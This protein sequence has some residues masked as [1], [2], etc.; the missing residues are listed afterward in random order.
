MKLLLL[1]EFFPR[2]EKGE[3]TGGVEARNFYLAKYFKG[4]IITFASKDNDSEKDAKIFCAKV[5]RL[6]FAYG[7]TQKTSLIK[8]F[9]FAFSC[10]FH[11]SKDFDI[12]EG[13]NF[14][15]HFAAIMIGKMHKKQIVLWYPDVWVGEWV[16]NVG[17]S[18]IFGEILERINLKLGKNAKYISISKSTK[19]KLIKHGI[20]ESNIAVIPCGVDEE[21]I[22]RIRN[23]RD[24]SLQIKFDFVVVNRLVGYKN[25]DLIIKTISIFVGAEHCSAPRLLIVGDGP[26]KENL[27]KLIAKNDIKKNVAIISKIEN[28]EELMRQILSA[29]VFV[30]ASLVEGFNIAAVEAASLGLPCLLSDIPAHQE[31]EKN[32]RGCLIFKNAKDLEN[33][34]KNLLEETKLH[35]KLSTLNKENSKNYFWKNIGEKTS[36]FYQ[37]I[38]K[39]KNS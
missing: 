18:G 22:S 21:E 24:H 38:L 23:G 7:Y 26:E 4:E 19:E 17:A 13:T 29:R 37:N 20:P 6:G 14:F 2:S 35:D 11:A 3:I 27:E 39:T 31:H 8:R 16:K 10:I 15:T 9:I 33:K 32:L 28:H 1:S 30:S 25:T 34:M 36:S 5:K 12:V